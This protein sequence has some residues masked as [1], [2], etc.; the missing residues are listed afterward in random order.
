MMPRSLGMLLPCLRTQYLFFTIDDIPFPNL[1]P[2]LCLFYF[3]N[4]YLE[5]GTSA[6]CKENLWFLFIIYFLSRGC[7]VR[8]DRERE[9]DGAKK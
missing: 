1:I 2:S 3:I 9:R 7:S 5:R 4:K 6:N 8:S